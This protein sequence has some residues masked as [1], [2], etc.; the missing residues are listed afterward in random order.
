MIVRS[1]ERNFEVM[2]KRHVLPGGGTATVLEGD[3]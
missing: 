3:L 2:G 1:S